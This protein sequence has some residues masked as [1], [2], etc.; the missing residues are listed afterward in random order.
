MRFAR[1]PSVMP[2]ARYPISQYEGRPWPQ[3]L[4][5]LSAIEKI[6]E[7]RAR[8]GIGRTYTIYVSK[9]KSAKFPGWPPVAKDLL[10]AEAVTLVAHQSASLCAV[11]RPAAILSRSSF[12]AVR[13]DRSANYADVSL[14]RKCASA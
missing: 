5:F 1:P 12:A 3:F 10:N 14:L 2:S 13:K 7:S 8:V 4:R 11:F 9:S 6:S